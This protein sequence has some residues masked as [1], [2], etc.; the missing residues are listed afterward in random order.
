MVKH[1]TEYKFKNEQQPHNDKAGPAL[2][3]MAAFNYLN[4]LATYIVISVDDFEQTEGPNGSKLSLIELLKREGINLNRCWPDGDYSYNEILGIYNKIHV[5]LDDEC[6]REEFRCCCDAT[7]SKDDDLDAWYNLHP[8]TERVLLFT[9]LLNEITPKDI[10]ISYDALDKS[11]RFDFDHNHGGKLDDV[12]GH[13]YF[14]L[15]DVHDLKI[16]TPEWHRKQYHL[17]SDPRVK[18]LLRSNTNG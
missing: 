9:E 8:Q 13:S 12:E 6:V 10:N 5:I 18:L 11:Q 1:C 3:L 14:Y 16:L 15:L 17:K 2:L 4:F 7:W